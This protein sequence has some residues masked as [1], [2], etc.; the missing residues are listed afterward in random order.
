MESMTDRME[1]LMQCY[2]LEL[3]RF[4]LGFSCEKLSLAVI[5]ATKI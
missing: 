1:R 3:L 4:R 2:F 5:E